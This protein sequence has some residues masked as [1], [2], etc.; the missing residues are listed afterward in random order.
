LAGNQGKEVSM[1]KTTCLMAA[2]A[3]LAAGFFTGCETLEGHEGAVVGSAVGAA[4]GALIGSAAAGSGNR[5]TGAAIGGVVGG[6]AG[7]VA[8]DQLHDKK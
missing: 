2:V 4:G 6:V 5:G 3:L 8:G 7:G 1:K